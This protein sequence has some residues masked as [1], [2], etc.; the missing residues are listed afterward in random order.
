MDTKRYLENL[1][2]MMRVRNQCIERAPK[3]ELEERKLV[4]WLKITCSI[5]LGMKGKEINKMVA[6]RADVGEGW[7][8]EDRGDQIDLY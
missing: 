3:T 4:L 2:R 7:S 1:V 8:V 6:G 5:I